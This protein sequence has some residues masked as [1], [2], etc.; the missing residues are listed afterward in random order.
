MDLN[1]IFLNLLIEQLDNQQIDN[2]N[3]QNPED[4]EQLPFNT[5]IPRFNSGEYKKIKNKWKQDRNYL[6][7][8]EME[9]VIETFNRKKNNLRPFREDFMA[10]GVP[11]QGIPNLPEIVSLKMVFPNFPADNIQKLKDLNSYSWPEIEFFVDRFNTADAEADITFN[12]AGDTEADRNKKAYDVWLGDWPSK[13]F[14]Q[15]GLVVHRIT[16]KNEAE[17]F[18]VLQHIMN[19][20][21][22]NGMN[23][24]ITVKGSTYYNSYRVRRSYYFV[25]RTTDAG[26]PREKD[27][28][29]MSVV[30]P[31]EWMSE[32]PYVI[33]PRPNGDR[34]NKTWKDIERIY[35]QLVGK[36]DLF[37]YF[38]KTKKEKYDESLRNINFEKGSPNNFI[39]QP[40]Y[41]QNRYIENGLQ[42]KSLDAFKSMTREQ[43]SGYVRGMNIDNYK[44]RFISENS[45]KPFLFL[46]YF[47]KEVPQVYRDIDTL[48][49]ERLNIPSGVKS[50]RNYILLKSF[51]KVLIDSSNPYIQILMNEDVGNAGVFNTEDGE[52]I[53]EPIYTQIGT[54]TRHRNVWSEKLN[55]NVPHYFLITKYTVSDAYSEGGNINTDKDTF[56]TVFP[57][58]NYEKQG[59]EKKYGRIIYDKIKGEAIWK[60]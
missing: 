27:D 14:D 54:K 60:A 17:A 38:P 5:Y 1:T 9:E 45:K 30:Q 47:K 40:R 19:K 59:D 6:T 18:G 39:A 12:I 32:G 58:G 29:Y 24:C 28:Y 48:I 23:W 37:K 55:T 42:I 41:I 26:T 50:I 20:K 3:P 15:D 44:N 31:S 13:I 8:Q 49:K 25:L 4:D 33:T 53:Y 7:D 2:Q 46:D 11:Y 10:E 36:E 21:L 56:Y 34:G 51:K 22:N 52:F 57:I 16:S 43:L 35:P